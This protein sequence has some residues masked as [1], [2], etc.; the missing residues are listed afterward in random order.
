MLSR[1]Q[2][3]PTQGLKLPSTVQNTPPVIV[4]VTSHHVL[5]ELVVQSSQ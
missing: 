1:S 3:Q 4:V 5:T 2:V